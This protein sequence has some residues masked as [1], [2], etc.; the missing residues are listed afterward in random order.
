[1]AALGSAKV[2]SGQVAQGLEILQEAVSLDR[3]AEPR[4]TH[5]SAL[6]A[7]AEASLMAGDAEKAL[8]YA[9]ESLRQ[10]EKYQER[11]EEASARWLLA[12]IMSVSGEDWEAARNAFRSAASLAAKLGLRPLLAH[13]YLGLGDLDARYSDT[14]A[15]NEC[16]ERGLMLLETLRMRR[17]VSLSSLRPVALRVADWL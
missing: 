17:W 13:C 1:M 15:G 8:S 4:T 7:L 3:S 2:R 11:G 10:T 6:T 16:R 14:R 9:T 5:A 12:T